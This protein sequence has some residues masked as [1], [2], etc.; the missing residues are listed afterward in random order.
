MIAILRTKQK[1]SLAQTQIWVTTNIADINNTYVEPLDTFDNR[2]NDNPIQVQFQNYVGLDPSY[3]GKV[4]QRAK[5]SEKETNKQDDN[6]TP[7]FPF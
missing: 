7:V 1:H 4:H 2:Y 3:F 5:K 6:Q